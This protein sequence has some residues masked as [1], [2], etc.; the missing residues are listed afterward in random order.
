MSIHRIG[1]LAAA[2]CAVGACASAQE[3][4]EGG[5]FTSGS[6]DADRRAEQRMNRAEQLQGE[7]VTEA[8]AEGEARTLFQ[9][10]GGEAGLRRIVDDFVD[11]AIA[12]PRVNWQRRGVERGG[13]LGIGGESAEWKATPENRRLLKDRF[14]QFLALAAGGPADYRGREI[15]ALH[16][17]MAISNSE[18]DATVGDLKASLDSLGVAAPE[19]KE[20]LALLEST[21]PQIVE[22][23]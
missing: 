13:F 11:R 1:L 8:A 20:L 23:R 22:E 14:Y 21:R 2:L 10:L 17:G 3:E 15:E 16:E 12:D 7:E 9:R 19:Q 4:E 6:R 18:F 5:F